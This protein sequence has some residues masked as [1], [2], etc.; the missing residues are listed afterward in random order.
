MEAATGSAQA[1]KRPL[2]RSPVPSG[3]VSAV[4]LWDFF[5]GRDRPF[6]LADAQSAGSA[7]SRWHVAGAQGVQLR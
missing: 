4:D 2:D 6:S 1:P 3:D 7:A 5:A